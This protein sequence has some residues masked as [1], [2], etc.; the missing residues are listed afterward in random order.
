[1]PIGPP[2]QA[3]APKSALSPVVA[4]MLRMYPALVDGTGSRVTSACQT[5]LGG[6][7]GQPRSAVP[8]GGGAGLAV[9]AGP[10]GAAPRGGGA[11][12]GAPPRAAAADRGEGDRTGEQPALAGAGRRGADP[13]G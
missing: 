12:G 2:S 7:L 4:P 13:P 11:G 9:G 1:M 6:R 8:A 5:L 10:D 3:P